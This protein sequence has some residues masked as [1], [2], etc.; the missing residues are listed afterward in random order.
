MNGRLKLLI[1][2]DR[3]TIAGTVYGTIVVMS[4]IAAGAKAYEH[5]LWRLV[6]LAGGSSL[7]LW[8]AHVY[9]DGLGESL[10]LGRRLT[11]DELSAI[12]RREYSVIAAAILPL[13]AVG[14]GAL[15]VIAQR[16]AVQLALWLGVV[17][18][19]AQGVRYARMA[20]MSP[21]AACAAVSLNLAIGLGLVALEILI[22]H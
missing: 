8:L 10:I 9:A 13:A 21:R 6:V 7:V 17:V 14:L 19:T 22:A 5:E 1:L 3:Q 18:L 2:G 20:H 4:V 16:T 12:T 11:V 15:G